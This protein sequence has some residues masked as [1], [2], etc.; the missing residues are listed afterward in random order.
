MPIGRRK[1][2]PASI[3]LDL[4]ERVA[5]ERN[6]VAPDVTGLQNQLGQKNRYLRK[7]ETTLK[8]LRGK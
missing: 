7:L 6:R 3:V 4:I 8:A 1:Y 5:A 2:E